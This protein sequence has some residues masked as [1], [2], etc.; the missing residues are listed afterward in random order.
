[1]SRS[2]F[3]SLLVLLSAAIA[4][5]PAVAQVLGTFTWQLQPYCNRVTVTLTGTPGGFVAAGT[6]DQCGAPKTAAATGLVAFN[7]DGTIGV[8]LEIVAAGA[9]ATDVT[10][11]VNPA[12]GHGTWSDSAGNSGALTLGGATPGLAPRPTATATLDVADNPRTQNDPCAVP[13]FV[14]LTLCGVSDSY[15]AHG[16]LGLPGLQVW[17]DAAGRVHIRGSIVRMGIWAS[18]FRVFVLPKGMRPKRTLFLTA[19]MS[20]ASQNLGGE[21][22]LILYGPEYP[23]LHGM[24]GIMFET[25]AADRALHFGELV[26]SVDR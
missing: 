10:A 16:G 2:S 26:F 21:A 13:P 24:V 19:A 20:R 11:T 4:P 1:M 15:W 5:A 9:V 17:K 18:G 3:L 23:S 8:A 25:D 22:K 6:D 12:N 14:E 7:P